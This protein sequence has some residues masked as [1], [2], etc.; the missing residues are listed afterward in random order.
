MCTKWEWG[1]NYSGL[2]HRQAAL[3]LSAPGVLIKDSLMPEGEAA[4]TV[5]ETICSARSMVQRQLFLLCSTV[6]V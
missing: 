5:K 3:P 4:G 1:P 2:G 6:A